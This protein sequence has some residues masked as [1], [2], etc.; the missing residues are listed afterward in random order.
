MIPVIY[1]TAAETA[2]AK[3]AAHTLTDAEDQQRFTRSAW[4]NFGR[5]Y[6]AAHPEMHGLN[7]SPDFRFAFMQ[8][9]LS[10]WVAEV[11]SVPLSPQEQRKAKSLYRE[12]EDAQRAFS[13]AQ[14]NWSDYQNELVAARVPVPSTGCNGGIVKL[15]SGKQA[16]IC[17]PWDNGV[18]FTPDFR[19]AVPKYP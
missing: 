11:A 7:F 14:K 15:P 13:Q 4:G 17:T 18:A 12:M 2:K 5:S 9:K 10:F 8:V 19:I 1:L 3:E 6:Q 16:T